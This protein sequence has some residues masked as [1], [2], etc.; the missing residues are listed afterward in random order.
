MEE[1]KYYNEFIRCYKDGKVERLFKQKGW[2]VVE[3]TANHCAG[4]NLI[5]IN[6]K[7]IKRHRLIAYCFLGLTNIVGEKGADN[8]IDHINGNK[9]DNRVENLR[10]TTNQGNLQNNPKAK[11]YT[12]NKQRNKWHAQI[13]VDNKSIHLGLFE[14][15]QEARQ[16]YLTAKAKYHI[17]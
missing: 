17:A 8:C 1:C 16:S 2:C 6:G 15:E 3:N 13:R 11:G 10:I 9:L 5:G 7:M 4:Y 14:T 12:W